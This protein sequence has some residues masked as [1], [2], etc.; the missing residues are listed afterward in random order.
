MDPLIIVVI[1]I[2]LLGAGVGF[3]FYN[4][5]NSD[6]VDDLSYEVDDSVEY[7]FDD[8]V[9]VEEEPEPEPEPEYSYGYAMINKPKSE[10][11]SD[12]RVN[13]NDD[14]TWGSDG[15]DKP[16]L[17]KFDTMEEC[18]DY[19]IN[20]RPESKMWSYRAKHS[21]PEYVKTCAA[22]LKLEDADGNVVPMRSSDSEIS[23][24]TLAGYSIASTCQTS[25]AGNA[26]ESEDCFEDKDCAGGL[27]C[28]GTNSEKPGEK[29]CM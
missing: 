8:S 12:F 7:E 4:K 19:V 28:T 2:L 15:G 14:G 6:E 25:H 23:G 10:S 16:T 13:V 1:I 18:R 17:M 26:Q 22:S 29:R 3:Y 20:N 21:K 11:W 27:S 24:C 9:A 5:Q